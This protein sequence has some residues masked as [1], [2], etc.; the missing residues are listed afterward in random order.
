MQH[1]GQAVLILEGEHARR[2]RAMLAPWHMSRFKVARRV[3]ANKR[4]RGAQQRG[5]HVLAFAGHHS[6]EQRA[7]HAVAGVHAGEM[8]GKRYA[9]S[10]G[11]SR[12]RKQA[13][14]PAP[15]LSDGIVPR[16]VAVRPLGAESGYGAVN[17]FGIEAFNLVVT[18]AAL[19]HHAGSEILDQHVG[20]GSELERDL[21][22][23]T[24]PQIQGDAALVAVQAAKGRS[25]IPFAP[26]AERIS[27]L[28]LFDL[29]DIG[30]HVRQ[31]LR[32]ERAGHVAGCFDD[33]D[34]CKRSAHSHVL[35]TKKSTARIS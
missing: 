34:S 1:K 28:R 32:S 16:H 24:G 13:Q 12:V 10:P 6:I 18:Q 2:R 15:R 33:F 30:P 29:N 35:K 19:F 14:Q 31:K 9:H 3:F 4:N 11:L 17:D 23:L 25:V 22:P 7:Q 26:A 27:S 21:A 5:L 8:I 20:S